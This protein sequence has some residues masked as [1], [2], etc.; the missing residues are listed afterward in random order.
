[1]YRF[2]SQNPGHLLSSSTM[3]S[4]SK[5]LKQSS[6]TCSVS[7]KRR[8]PLQV[9]DIS[10]DTSDS[11]RIIDLTQLSPPLEAEQ[12][13]LKSQKVL[14]RRTLSIA[15]KK[16]VRPVF[17]NTNAEILQS[18]T[19]SK[20]AEPISS[21]PLISSVKERPWKRST[22]QSPLL[23]SNTIKACCSQETSPSTPRPL[24][25]SLE[26]AFAA[27]DAREV[28]NQRGPVSMPKLETSES[29][30]SF[31]QKPLTCSGLTDTMA[32]NCFCWTTLQMLQS[33]TGNSLC[34]WMCTNTQSKLKEVLL[35]QLGDTLSSRLTQTHVPGIYPPIQA[36]NV[37]L[38][39]DDWTTSLKPLGT[40][41]T[42]SVTCSKPLMPLRPDSPT[43]V[44]SSQETLI[45][46]PTDSQTDSLLDQAMSEKEKK[47]IL[48]TVFRK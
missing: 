23:S 11:K 32:K 5:N 45:L 27:T 1:M 4:E 46:S 22:T 31:S 41:N 25:R 20:V 43:L 33:H 14:L 3:M 48:S 29:L 34:G 12:P 2:R 18:T 24:K 42:G 16:R 15:P 17:I 7:K 21:M 6:Q 44:S 37:M 9:L 28:E 38:S 19:E 26:S 13:T 40:R 39:R 30:A 36:P 47:L 10:K 35:T 8:V